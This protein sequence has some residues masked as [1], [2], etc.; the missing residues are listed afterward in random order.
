MLVQSMSV[1]KIGLLNAFNLSNCIITSL[2]SLQTVN[3]QI[4]FC[5]ATNCEFQ[6][7]AAKC[8]DQPLNQLKKFK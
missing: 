6:V 3:H 7:N 2:I 4:A 1:S 8:N 5:A